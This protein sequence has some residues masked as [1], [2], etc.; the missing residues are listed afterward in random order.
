[1]QNTLR[2][3]CRVVTCGLLAHIFFR[4]DPWPLA[5][6]MAV[7]SSSGIRNDVLL[8]D[9]VPCDT[10]SALKCYGQTKPVSNIQ[11]DLAVV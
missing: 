6:A 1:M 9:A 10:L 2:K 5:D 11:R 8:P 7:E 3:F 4:L